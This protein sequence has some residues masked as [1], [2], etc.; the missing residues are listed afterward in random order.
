MGSLPPTRWWFRRGEFGVLIGQPK[1][2][3]IRSRSFRPLEKPMTDTPETTPADESRAVQLLRGQ[4]KRSLYNA[5]IAALSLQNYEQE[6]A[7]CKQRH[8]EYLAEVESYTQ[9][10]RMLGVEP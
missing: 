10:L 5:D 9:A 1:P 2:D 4:I 3:Q 7:D 6:V 8:A